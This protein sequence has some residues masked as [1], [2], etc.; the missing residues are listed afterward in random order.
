[1]R[2]LSSSLTFINKRVFP[3]L[4]FGF[5]TVFEIF[6]L[7]EFFDNNGPIFLAI[8]PLVMMLFGYGIMKWLIFDLMDEVYLDGDTLI[9]RNSD[10]EDRF[11][12]TNILNVSATLMTNPE[13]I[14]LTLREPS[15]FGHEITFSPLVRLWRFSKNPIA[16]ELMRRAHG[17][18][19]K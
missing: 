11:P 10:A 12:V 15:K 17:L 3:V 9:V 8:L 1:M 18:E 4:W 13:R 2:K 16:D 19:A 14:T 6:G 7:T 5:L